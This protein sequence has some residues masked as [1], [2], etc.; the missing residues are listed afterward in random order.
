MVIEIKVNT[1]HEERSWGDGREE[2]K[3]RQ[4][5]KVVERKSAPIFF[6]VLMS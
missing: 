1:T 3:R 4:H 5:E 6:L 2:S